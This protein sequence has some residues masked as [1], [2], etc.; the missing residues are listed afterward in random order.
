MNHPALKKGP[1]YAKKGVL[2][3]RKGL[4]F[5]AK[6]LLFCAKGLLFSAKGP[7]FGKEGLLHTI[8][9]TRAH[10]RIVVLL[11]FYVFHLSHLSIPHF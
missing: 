9:L 1:L 11:T 10:V 7:L 6:G 5:C 4:L 3:D 2:Y 8:F